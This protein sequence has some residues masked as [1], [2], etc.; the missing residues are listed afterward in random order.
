MIVLKS[1]KQVLVNPVLLNKNYVYMQINDITYDASGYRASYVYY[2]IVGAENQY[3]PIH[4]G[5]FTLSI[6]QATQIEQMG[7]G[8]E[9]NNFTQKFNDLI[10]KATIHQMGVESVFGLQ[11]TDWEVL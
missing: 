8:I 1:K 11:A 4:T 5:I 9:G 6:A 2:N 7:G 3:A 10:V